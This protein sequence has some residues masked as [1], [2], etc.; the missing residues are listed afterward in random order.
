V[1][2][3]KILFSSSEVFPFSKTGGLADMA[4]FL[5]KSLKDLGHEVKVI[6]PYYKSISKHHKDMTYKGTKNIVMGGIETIVHYY[7]LI[8]QDMSFIFVKIMHYFDAVHLYDITIA[9]E[10]FLFLVMQF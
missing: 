5:P 7:E 1:I 8:Y 10:R 4:L 3:L 9:E 6:T 2:A